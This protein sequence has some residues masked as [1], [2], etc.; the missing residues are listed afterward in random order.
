MLLF[1]VAAWR[2]DKNKNKSQVY[3]TEG[4]VAEAPGAGEKVVS[5]AKQCLNYGW[6]AAAETMLRAQGVD[7]SQ[8]DWVVKAFGGAKCVDSGLDFAAL[9]HAL[10]GD[11]ALTNGR[12]IRIAAEWQPG[13]PVNIDAIIAGL[14]QGN[15][16]LMGWNGR[17][18][19]LTGITYDRE[20][21][22]KT[23]YRVYYIK[24]MRLVDPMAAK[25]SPQRQV[26]FVRDQIGRAHV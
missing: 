21:N 23:G 15:V 1:T 13:A 25:N 8:T 12:K 7:I 22:S 6:A 20:I 5:A 4:L 2:G 19:L 3:R 9:A 16:F 18:Y 10:E 26:K 11:Y 14:V 17:A 24:E